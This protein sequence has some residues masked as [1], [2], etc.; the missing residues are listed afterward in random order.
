MSR[1]CQILVIADDLTGAA[2]TGVQFCPA[3]GPVL[4]TDSVEPGLTESAI[5]AT[6]IC[7]F[8]NTRHQNAETAALRVHA[9]AMRIRGLAPRMIYKKIDSCLR[10]N[11]GVEIEALLQAT[12]AVASFVAPAYPQQGRTTVGDVH[13]IDGVPVAQTEIGRDPRC[14]VN[15]SRL[16]VLLATQCELPVGHVDLACL[17]GGDDALAGHVHGL[18]DQGCRHI[19]FDAERPVHLDAIAGLARHRFEDILLVGSAGLAAG[20]ARILV[21]ELP[22]PAAGRPGIK[23]WLLVCGSASQVLAD[24]A[25]Q[26]AQAT[27]WL[28]LAI[29]PSRL[30]TGGGPT[31]SEPWMAKRIDDWGDGGLILSIAPLA[32]SGPTE[33]PERVVQGLACLA[34]VLLRAGNP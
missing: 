31:P 30:S 10:G 18:L 1:T 33:P 20:L 7:V 6:G 22:P 11:L 4:L 15:E 21:R 2:D 14:P 26:L 32:E 24:Q 27:G 28:H 25:A 16:S 19:A 9:E 34:A 29:D 8:T 17:E 23:R 12:A 13:R 5:R 3:V